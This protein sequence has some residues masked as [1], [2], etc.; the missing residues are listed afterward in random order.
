LD[1]RRVLRRAKYADRQWLVSSNSSRSKF[2]GQRPLEWQLRLS[3][4]LVLF[5]K[6]EERQREAATPV[7]EATL[8]DRAVSN[9]SG[10]DDEEKQEDEKTAGKILAKKRRKVHLKQVKLTNYG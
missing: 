9:I 3:K 10:S 8:A 6:D 2:H 7:K 5:I 4:L 1:K